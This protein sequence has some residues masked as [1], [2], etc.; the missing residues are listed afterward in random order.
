MVDSSYFGDMFCSPAMRAVFSDE[1]RIASWLETEVALARAEARVGIVPVHCA[2][3]IAAAAK[4]ENLD[5]AA[6]KAEF[7]RVG[8]PIMPLV[9]QLAKACS[10]E[11]AKWVHWGSTT[12][13]ILDTGLA[14]QLREGIALLEADL[15][16]IID[17]VAKLAKAHRDTVMPGRTLQQHAAPITFGYKVAVWLDEL[18][19]H[20]ERLPE[21]RRR[22]LVGQC[23]GAVGTLA[24][25]G[26]H[27]LAVRREMMAELGLGEPA[28]SWHTARDSLAELL[29]W[30]AM[31][32]ATMA[33]MANEVAILMRTEIDE[34]R[35][36]YEP[37]RGASSTMPQKRNPIACQPVIA[38][39]HRLREISSCGLTAMIQEHERPVGP[40]HLEWSII[41]DAFLHASGAFMHSR[42]IFE[43]LTVD[44]GNMLRNLT[45]AGGFLLAEAVMMGLA[46]HTGRNDAHDIVYAAAS[47]AMDSGTGLRAALVADPAVTAHLSIDEID[48][49]LDPAAYTGSA[50]EMVDAVLRKLDHD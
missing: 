6:M 37:G 39:A 18:L 3:Q 15:D 21:V 32:S 20:R 4:L 41:P 40:M 16:G 33:K 26:E 44:A 8:F 9:H 2:E 45:G 12:Q 48:A 28:I 27:G 22:A 23:G 31:V 7:D 47:R 42:R 24:T 46:P 25:L 17:A 50:G 13:D 5:L 34:L 35:E 38:A 19:R 1:R 29:F 11:A 14:L 30:L 36:P 10:P 49:L 43:G